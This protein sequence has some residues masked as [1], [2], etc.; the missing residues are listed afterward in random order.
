MTASSMRLSSVG[1]MPGK[2]LSCPCC[3]ISSMSPSSA[4]IVRA[5]F[6]YARTSKTLLPSFSESRVAMSSSRVATSF[7]FIA[8]FPRQ[9]LCLLG[10]GGTFRQAQIEK[11][12]FGGGYLERI[13]S[14]EFARQVAFTVEVDEQPAIELLGDEDRIPGFLVI[15]V[16][17]LIADKAAHHACRDGAFIPFQHK[18]MHVL[19]QHQVQR[20]LR[21]AEQHR[22]GTFT[23]I[24]I[25]FAEG[26]HR[27]L[28]RHLDLIMRRVI[29]RRHDI[30]QQQ[31]L[32]G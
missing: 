20:R 22:V 19:K 10:V 28:D 7:L 11:F 21:V 25:S 1:P 13:P 2:P 24:V 17:L 15:N 4:L 18:L 16:Q 29:C 27:G 14:F 5:A 8:L 26:Q 32:T 6:S 31:P 3:T 23:K 30:G 9:K 12:G